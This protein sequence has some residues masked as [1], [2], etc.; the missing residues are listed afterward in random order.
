[1]KN[2]LRRELLE[3]RH[4]RRLSRLAA[5]VK[6]H[7]SPEAG[8]K[9][10]IFF[11]ASTD[12]H[13]MSL[14]SAF[15][16]LAAWSLRLQ[17]VRV[18]HFHC[19]AGMSRCVLGT[20]RDDPSTPP[21]CKVCTAHTS[22]QFR[23]AEVREFQY[24]QASSEIKAALQELDLHALEV[25]EAQSLPLG[26]LALPSLRWVLRRHHLPDD[27]ST[28]FLYR[29]YI[30]SAWNVAREFTKLLDETNPRAVIV[31]NGMFFP[32]A[33]VRC[34][35][36]RRGIRVIT[37]EVALQ[38]FTAFFTEGEATAY[39]IEIPGSFELSPEQNARLDRYLEERFKGN[40]SMAGIRFWPEMQRL[41]EPFL[42]RMRQ[43]RQVIPVFTNV[44]FDTSQPH[45]NVVFEDMFQWLEVVLDLARSSP[46][47]LFVIRAHP[48]EK[49]TW[50]ES[51]ESV[52]DWVKSKNALSLPNVAFFDADEYV[53]S[54]ELIQ[55]AKFVMVYNSSIGL[56]AS[57]MGA[58][59]LCAGKARFTQ[60]PT[61]FFPQ[62]KAAFIETA[63]R[64]L[65]SEEIAVPAEFQQ[66][67]RKFLYY[68]LFRTSLPFGEYLQAHPMRG[69]VLLR[70]FPWQKLLPENSPG[71]KAVVDGVLK[72][73]NFLLEE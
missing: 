23:G 8:S 3:R 64:F 4:F 61:V 14:N 9:P 58:P 7:G 16:L 22:R 31:F 54:Y 15:H 26:K 1:M 50:K 59:V 27:E 38:P 66:N 5:E 6:Q 45:S 67:A 28:R 72:G 43:Y 47:S 62:T 2:R 49:R 65:V 24:A 39:P 18:I 21:P 69:M 48:D 13:K 30:L 36:L 20:D 73:G 51:R 46:E 33:V 60:I 53:S 56:E 17:G 40:F 10:V 52:G 34:I 63:G 68:Q 55:H 44:I 57:L 11:K 41:P 29:E 32:E 19:Q 71:V 42:E 35:A 37:H 70:D 12:I 25:F